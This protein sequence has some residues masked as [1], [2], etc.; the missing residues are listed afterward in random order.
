MSTLESMLAELKMLANKSD[1]PYQSLM[2]TFLADK[3]SKN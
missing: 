2:K 1:V 3:I